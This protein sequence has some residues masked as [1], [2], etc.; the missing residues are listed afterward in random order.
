MLVRK[1]RYPQ[2]GDGLDNDDDGYTDCD[3]QDCLI[4]TECSQDVDDT[5]VDTDDPVDTGDTEETDTQDTSDTEETGDTQVDPNDQDGD[6]FTPS[7]GDCDDSDANANPNG[8]DST[9]DGKDQDCDGV[10]GP[11][12]D[13]DGF[14]DSSAGGTDCNDSDA[15]V[16]P[17]GTD[18]PGDCIDQDCDGSDVTRIK[19]ITNDGETIVAV[20][21]VNCLPQVWR[22][23]WRTNSQPSWGWLC[24]SVSYNTEEFNA[25]RW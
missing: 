24:L 3:D 14:V 25:H 21:V 19:I 12:Q 7:D 18:I 23:R 11:D 8:N 2:N 17:Y 20:P 16:N 4:Y 1:E 10:D 22:C 5:G 6:G 13:A 9:I 15:S